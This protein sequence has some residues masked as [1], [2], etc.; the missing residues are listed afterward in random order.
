M[1]NKVVIG[2]NVLGMFM[3]D[4]IMRNVNYTLVATI[5]RSGR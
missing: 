4:I 5:N 1:P 2:L 3:E